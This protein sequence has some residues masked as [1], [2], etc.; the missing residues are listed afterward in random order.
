[1][2]WAQFG[3]GYLYNR[4]NKCATW[5]SFFL[6]GS[7]IF[8]SVPTKQQLFI[9]ASQIIPLQLGISFSLSN[10]IS[11][12]SKWLGGFSHFHFG[13]VPHHS[14]RGVLEKLNENIFVLSLWFPNSNPPL[15]G[16]YWFNLRGWKSGEQ[17]YMVY[18]TT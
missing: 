3:I 8:L 9:R 16:I 13:S 1:M 14:S 18:K 10:L 2:L 11:S 12:R 4:K 6:F 5:N 7:H 15:L 17:L